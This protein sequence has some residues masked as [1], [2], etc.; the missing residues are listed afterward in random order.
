MPTRSSSP[1]T[2]TLPCSTATHRHSAARSVRLSCVS[3]PLLNP[4]ATPL[5]PPHAAP[6]RITV[7]WCCTT[8]SGP[9]P[10]YVPPR[11][12]LSCLMVPLRHAFA[13][14]GIMV[15]AVVPCCAAPRRLDLRHVLTVACPRRALAPCGADDPQPPRN[16]LATLPRHAVRGVVLRPTPSGPPPRIPLRPFA[17][18]RARLRHVVWSCTP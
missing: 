16:P 18:R 8:P 11:C 13:S 17:R 6:R 5:R 12:A 4:F 1:V 10:R 9:P 2:A 3:L 15:L 7:L 14:H